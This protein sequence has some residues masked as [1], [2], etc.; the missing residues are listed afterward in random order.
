MFSG[1]NGCAA[2]QQT[3]RVCTK[4]MMRCWVLGFKAHEIKHV[5]YIITEALAAAPQVLGHILNMQKTL[6]FTSASPLPT[7]AHV[8]GI[9]HSSFISASIRFRLIGFP[10]L[11][12]LCGTQSNS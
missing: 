7:N 2:L 3:F 1:G 11:S 9:T 10:N 8:R 6:I 12:M 4:V 5:S